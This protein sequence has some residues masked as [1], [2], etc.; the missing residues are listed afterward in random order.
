[1]N[2]LSKI[3]DYLHYKEQHDEP[4]LPTNC[5][6]DLNLNELFEK[7][8]YCHS[9]IG[10]QYLYYLLLSGQNSGIEKQGKL[11]AILSTN[12]ELCTFL[13]GA[14]NKL[15]HP[16]AYSIASIIDRPHIN[17]SKKEMAYI[18]V[19]R[20]LPFF[21]LVLLLLMHS[22]IPILLFVLSLLINIV[23]HYRNKTKIQAYFFSIPQLLKLIKQA[24][25]LVQKPEFTSTGVSIA[26]DL[27]AIK[28]LKKYIAYFRFNLRLESDMAILAYLIA[29]LMRIFFLHEAY[30]VGKTSE[31]LKKHVNAIHNLYRFIGFLD[32]L[33]AISK[34]RK[35]LPYYCLPDKSR[36]GERLRTT[37]IYHP[38]IEKCVPNDIML[39][40]KSVLIT[41][42]NM[43]GKTSFMRSIGINLLTAKTLHT[44]FATCFEIDTDLSL[45]TSI[46]QNDNLT[47]GKSYFMQEV[48]TVKEFVDQDEGN[49]LYLLD[50]L[51]RGTN[52]K[53]RIA[54]TKAV[55]S[56]L[57]SKGD[58]VF[59]ATHDIE[60]SELLQSQ[61]ELYYFC[62]S[63]KDDI[64][65]FDYKLKVG[66]ATERNAI[67]L[68]ELCEYPAALLKDAYKTIIT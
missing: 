49:G 44:C 11:L 27:K 4:I 46:H 12:D 33:L 60:L 20:F 31:L 7:I 45:F 67:K 26:E 68:L 18:H 38:L 61:Y 50:E 48:L 6:E 34:L 57:A 66:V 51:F 64:L 56:Y 43:S 28:G 30:A 15:N 8:D 54:I 19:C 23:L 1:M 52:T 3:A 22:L 21:F 37:A 55:L 40:N 35:T 41:G 42:S 39:P 53:E 25:V 13:T 59:V 14:L 16:D 10:Q 65:Y 5:A 63:I 29:E 47:E 9:C 2:N 32:T 62:E 58:L 24:E 36:E 17:I